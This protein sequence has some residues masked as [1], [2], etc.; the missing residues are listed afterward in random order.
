MTQL[1][2][3]LEQVIQ[4]SNEQHNGSLAYLK[5]DTFH[6]C[7]QS[8]GNRIVEDIIRNGESKDGKLMFSFGCDETLGRAV[9]ESDVRRMVG[10]NDVIQ[11][12]VTELFDAPILKRTRIPNRRWKIIEIPANQVD[13]TSRDVANS[14]RYVS[15][16]TLERYLDV[17][18]HEIGLK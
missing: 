8:M 18:H 1:H 12:I 9:N 2:P 13:P 11:G 15:V 4:Q 16:A 5:T 7:I 6:V 14:M 10:P 3:L 17:I